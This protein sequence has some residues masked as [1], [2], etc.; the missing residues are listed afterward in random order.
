MSLQSYLTCYVQNVQYAISTN[1]VLEIFPLPELQTI[2]ETP[3]DILGVLNLRGKLLPVMQLRRRISK[4]TAPCTA[5]DSV[6][7][8]ECGDLQIGIIVDRVSEV[9]ALPTDEIDRD[10]A[11]GRQQHVNTAFLS[12]MLQFA[13]ENILILNPEALVSLPDE[14]ANW[15]WQADET[16]GYTGEFAETI[17][18][19]AVDGDFYE[20]YFPTATPTE[21]ELLGKRAIDLR[22]AGIDNDQI[23]GIPLA[24]FGLGGEYFGIRLSLVREFINTHSIRTMPCAP[25]QII[26]NMNLRGEIMTLVDVRPALN[27]SNVIAPSHQAVVT[28]VGDVVA[29]LSIDELHDIIYLDPALL[30][31]VPVANQQSRAGLVES[32]TPYRDT[33]LSVLDLPQLLNIA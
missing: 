18:I 25:A 21:R 16:G 3:E 24:V 11:F 20:L 6:I 2:P 29:G 30:A 23:Q 10:L 28:Q 9:Y 1:N 33:M 19:N 8:L 27:L 14:V 4:S 15:V 26:G 5:A 13:D 12:G 31:A 22:F 7:V 32:T 17:S